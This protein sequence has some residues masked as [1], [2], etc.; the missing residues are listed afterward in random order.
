LLLGGWLLYQEIASRLFLTRVLR[1][2]RADGLPTTW[3]EF[4]SAYATPE[5]A[6]RVDLARALERLDE[7]PRLTGDR[8]AFVPYEGRACDV[9]ELGA[10]FPLEIRE[11][12]RARIEETR[13][14]LDAVRSAL[15]SGSVVYAPTSDLSLGVFSISARRQAANLMRMLALYYT[16]ESDSPA[17]LDVVADQFR[18][19]DAVRG[20]ELLIDGLVR[21]AVQNVA[22]ASLER[23]LATMDV[24]PRAL[25]PLDAILSTPY[26]IE[27]CLRG[28]LVY[29]SLMYIQLHLDDDAGDWLADGGAEFYWFW[30][31]RPFRRGWLRMNEAYQLHCGLAG[32]AVSW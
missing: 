15:A 16:L 6:R 2:L 7:L 31:L 30:T 1:E 4:E 28:E 22:V 10:P 9:P 11:A 23:S 17:A 19:A 32:G 3:E 29:L 8:R 12:L 26:G 27:D 13:P 18:L 24:A 20:S 5:P 14:Y 21:I 25:G